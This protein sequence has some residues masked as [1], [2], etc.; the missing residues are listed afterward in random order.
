MEPEIDVRTV[1]NKPPPSDAALA[2]NA[3]L[4]TVNVPELAKSL[5]PPPTVVDVLDPFSTVAPS[6]MTGTTFVEAMVNGV[7]VPP[8]S[9][10]TDDGPPPESVNEASESVF[11]SSMVKAPL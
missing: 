3:S 10:I 8:P 9:K 11:S 4:D 2:V 1:E 7:V 5:T 6:R